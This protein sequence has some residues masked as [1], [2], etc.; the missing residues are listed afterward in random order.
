MDK[1]K[2]RYLFE[3]DFSNPGAYKSG[4]YLRE[5]FLIRSKNII[6]E[7]RENLV[8]VLI[9]WIDS[10]TEPKTMLAVYLADEL[11][12]FELKNYVMALKKDIIK[13]NVFPRDYVIKIDRILKKL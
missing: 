13:N 7:D 8:D 2:I 11:N 4:E 5:I 1:E 6:N 3:T 9:D 10:R 12:I